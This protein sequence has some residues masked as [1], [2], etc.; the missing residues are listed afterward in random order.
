MH[1]PTRPATRISGGIALIFAAAVALGG[2]ASGKQAL[3]QQVQEL[4]R[5]VLR[6]RAERA[7]LAARNRALDDERLV[8]ERKI[9]QCAETKRERQLQI[10]RLTEG[11]AIEAPPVP[12]IEEVDDDDDGK[13]PLLQL[14]GAPRIARSSAG[15][16][17]PL[18][19]AGAVDSL[20]VVPLGGGAAAAPG[21]PGTPEAGAMSSFDDGYRAFSNRS[22]AEALDLFAAFLKDNPDHRFADNA[23][24]W[25]GE[26]YLAQGKL[27]KAIGE[28]ERLIRKFPRSEKGPSALYRIGFAYDQLND[29]EKASEYYFKVVERY[30]G[31]DA[32]R[33]A[34]RR[35]AAIRE[36]GVRRTG[37]VQTAAQR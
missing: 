26:C 35:V 31:T 6:L 4:E 27:L 2:C 10:V 20:G 29:R 22:Y 11:Q 7:N 15:P 12:L 9:D 33:K 24:F 19:D 17:P 23:L 5:E 32:A 14:A 21:D 30:P 13:R 36:A 37:L 25:R 8:H 28:L 1:D 34:S 18:P 3:E 16:L